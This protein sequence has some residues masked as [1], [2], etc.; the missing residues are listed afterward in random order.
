[1]HHVYNMC[2]LIISKFSFLLYVADYIIQMVV[3]STFQYD[4]SKLNYFCVK[5]LARRHHIS[6]SVTVTQTVVICVFYSVSNYY[7]W[8]FEI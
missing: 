3:S 6:V 5:I 1:L 7:T 4:S 2:K 8:S